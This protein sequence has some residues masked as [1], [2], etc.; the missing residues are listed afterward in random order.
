M[1][2]APG[3]LTREFM[4]V[5][6]ATQIAKGMQGWSGKKRVEFCARGEA[7]LHPDLLKILWIFKKRLPQ[8]QFSLT[9]NGDVLR[10]M[11]TDE[12]LEL[13]RWGLN[14]LIV[15]A[16]DHYK[17][18]N[19]IGKAI[20]EYVPYYNFYY[21]KYT[22]FAYHSAKE[23]AFVLIP[24]IMD[25]A[26]D[27]PVTRKLNNMA[28]NVDFKKAKILGI[29]RLKNPL[30]KKCTRPFRDL[31]IRYD[32]TIPVCCYD[33]RNEWVMGQFDGSEGLL[34]IWN[35][36]QFQIARHLLFNRNRHVSPCYKCNYNGGFR[37]GFIHDPWSELPNDLKPS[38]SFIKS[39][40]LASKTKYDGLLHPTV[41][42]PPFFE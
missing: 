21:N 7:L 22:P 31:Q 14:I 24:S 5:K 13:F 41:T 36:L 23:K 35:N 29:E 6:L 42:D 12:I 25:N 20:E 27:N 1:A 16:Y 8:A 34:D 9:T 3:G 32:G 28:G 33:F 40:V 15:D 30:V 39:L 17:E 26:K 38:S 18:L 10:L 4:T 37:Q 11:R 19:A 2:Q